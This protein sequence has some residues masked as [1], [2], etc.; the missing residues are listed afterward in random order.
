[1]NKE[2]IRKAIRDVI[3]TMMDGV[4]TK[5]LERDPFIPE[6]HHASK[7]VYAA[8]V[9]DEIF[10]GSHFERRFVTPFGHVWER[11]ASVVAKEHHGACEIEHNVDGLIAE[12]RLRRIQE[13]LNRLEHPSATSGK[14]VVPNWDDELG[15]ILNGGGQLIPCTVTCDLFINSK[16]N[17]ECYAIELKGPLPNSD[18]TKVSKEKMFKLLAMDKRPVDHAYYALPYNPYGTREKYAWSFPR[19]WFDMLKD[20]SV[21]MGVEFWDLIGGEGTYKT[22]ISVVNSLGRGYRERIYREFLCIEP[23]ANID[24]DLLK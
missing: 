17:G 13:V 22:F 21:K 6:N 23:P 15:Y 1:M 18:Q 4:M 14:R 5:V 8:L 3:T 24:M 2:K 20:E 11:L 9:P 7:P 12:G 19:R 10:K 16:L